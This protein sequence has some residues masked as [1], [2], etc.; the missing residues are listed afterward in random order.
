MVGRGSG[1]QKPEQE[2][3]E[4]CVRRIAL[5]HSPSGCYERRECVEDIAGESFD[6]SSVA[7]LF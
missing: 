2:H 7:A 5:C 4:E 6:R 1:E 3:G